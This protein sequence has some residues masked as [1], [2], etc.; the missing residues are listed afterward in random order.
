MNQRPFKDVVG[1]YTDD[2]AYLMEARSLSLMRL[3]PVFLIALSLVVAAASIFIEPNGDR[4]TRL[5]ELVIS[6]ALGSLTPTVFPTKV[7]S[8]TMK[9][10]IDSRGHYE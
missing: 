6:G 9:T 5:S 3:A 7:L 8:N 4:L 2:K 10:P 1:T